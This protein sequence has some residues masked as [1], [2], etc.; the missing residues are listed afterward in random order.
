M[1]TKI[2]KL[3]LLAAVANKAFAQNGSSSHLDINQAQHGTYM[4]GEDMIEDLSIDDVLDAIEIT[5]QKA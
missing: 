1:K 4:D 5:E 3:I 2:N